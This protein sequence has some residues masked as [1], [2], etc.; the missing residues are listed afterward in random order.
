MHFETT[1]KQKI[2]TLFISTFSLMC[3][4]YRRV[5]FSLKNYGIYKQPKVYV[6]L[7]WSVLM[8]YIMLNETLLNTLFLFCAVFVDF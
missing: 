5:V 6:P 7:I 3:S 1:R 4:I 2:S 8:S